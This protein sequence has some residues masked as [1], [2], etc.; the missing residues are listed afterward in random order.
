MISISRILVPAVLSPACGW[1]VGY[2]EEL[3]QRLGSKLFFLHVGTCARE[4]IEA[5]VASR[6]VSAAPEILIREGEPADVIVQL[7]G[8][9]GIDLILMP[10]HAHGRFRRFLLGSVT[11]KVLHDASCPVLTGVHQADL[12][13]AK[14]ADFRSLVCA[15][16]TNE[17]FG[18]VVQFASDLKALLNA[19]LTLVH[20]I[21]AADETSDNRGEVEIRR[22]MFQRANERFAVLCRQSNVNLKVLS[23]GGPVERVV[24]EAALREKADLVVVG[25]GHTLQEL[26]RLRTHAYAIIRNSPCPVVS[27]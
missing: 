2:S 25:R 17:S 7:S 5:F 18:P 24:R 26:G 4:Q 9:L 15:V 10:T 22:H 8:E 1:A 27:V 11:A 14:P 21:P 13:T 23:A 6:I 3:A 12:P 19:T 16:D 20:A